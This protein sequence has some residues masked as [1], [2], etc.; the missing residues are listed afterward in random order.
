M[1]GAFV[2]LAVRAQQHPSL[3][4]TTLNR[5]LNEESKLWRVHLDREGVEE[6]RKQDGKVLLRNPSLP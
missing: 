4:L 5:V 2:H 1:N 6:R 3:V